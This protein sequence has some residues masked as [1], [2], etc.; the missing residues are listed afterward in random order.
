MSAESQPSFQDVF[1]ES[2]FGPADPAATADPPLDPAELFADTDDATIGSLVTG[3]VIQPRFDGDTSQLPAEVCW[4]M[5]ELV[6]AP[7]VTDK[8]RKHWAVIMQYEDVLRSRLSEMGLILQINREHRFAFTE[9]ADDSA[10]LSRTI[11]RTRTLSLAASALA[12]YLYQQYLIAPDDP[13]VETA[14][15]H[16]HMLAYKRPGDTDEAGFHKKITTAIKLL[17]DAAIIKPIKGTSRYLIYSVITSLL[18][19]ERIDTLR[20]RY[21]AIARGEAVEATDAEP[22]EEPVA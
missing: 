8:Q 20:E 4:T 3:P 22:E 6:A 17:D 15:M 7:H 18:T 14:D 2:I 10:P 9:Q 1:G 11:L 13:L 21:L 16:D 12:L 5:Q 19:V